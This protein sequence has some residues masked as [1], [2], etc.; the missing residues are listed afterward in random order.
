MEALWHYLFYTA[1]RIVPEEQHML[2]PLS[3][4]FPESHRE[5]MQQILFESFNVPAMYT[6]PSGM[7][8]VIGNERTMVENCL[9]E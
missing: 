7:F 2:L 3:P 5:K 4:L 9:L 6:F 8:D 1:L